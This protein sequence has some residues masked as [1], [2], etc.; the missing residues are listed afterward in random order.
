M[1]TMDI[2]NYYDWNLLVSATDTKLGFGLR[3]SMYCKL[4][5]VIDVVS[6]EKQRTYSWFKRPLIKQDFS[7]CLALNIRV[8]NT[9]LSLDIS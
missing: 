1:Q 8:T 6:K 4:I 7:L 2:P 3:D 5:V 9:S